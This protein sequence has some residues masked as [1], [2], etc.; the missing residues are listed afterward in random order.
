M[1]IDNFLK[2]KRHTGFTLLE[3]LVVIAIIGLFSSIVM[4]SLSSVRRDG[5]NTFRNKAIDEYAKAL[6][7][8]YDTNGNYP[9]PLAGSADGYN[10]L[11]TF[12]VT[13]RVGMDN[14]PS[15]NTL[16]SALSPYIKMTEPFPLI[17]VGGPLSLGYQGPLYYCVYSAGICTGESKLVWILEN[18]DQ[19]CANNAVATNN[20]FTN[21]TECELYLKTAF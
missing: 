19:T 1:R 8:Y 11:A 12:P 7:L 14:I 17:D 2:K 16:N 13:C 10:C 5:R 18:I 4:A 9:N 20:L 15:N 6:Y 3:L 21:T